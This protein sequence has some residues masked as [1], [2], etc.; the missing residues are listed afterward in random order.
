MRTSRRS[1]VT[2]QNRFFMV[3][4][5][6]TT[7]PTPKLEDHS[8]RILHDCLLNTSAL[9][10]TSTRHFL[11]QQPADTPCCGDNGRTNSF[12]ELIFSYGL[13]LCSRARSEDRLVAGFPPRRPWFDPGSSQ[14]GFVDKVVLGR[15]FSE[16]FGFPCQSSFHQI[17]HHHNH[18]GQPTR[19]QSVAAVPSGP[20][21][22]PP[23]TKR[24]V[25][26]KQS[27]PK[28]K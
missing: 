25:R 28:E 23:P 18:P 11:H 7:R 12:A 24:K 19:D 2:F 22:T 5:S 20:S 10:F 9:L 16:Y 15:V 26:R 8:L 6:S 14:V 13:F 27:G 3:R 21:R 4:S 17:L 1:C